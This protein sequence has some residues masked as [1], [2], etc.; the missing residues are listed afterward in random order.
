MTELDLE[1][2]SLQNRPNQSRL[3]Q[4]IIGRFVLAIIVSYLIVR[5]FIDF[6]FSFGIVFGALFLSVL[7]IIPLWSNINYLQI[8]KTNYDCVSVKKDGIS[9]EEDGKLIHFIPQTELSEIKLTFH[10]SI[11]DELNI[12]RDSFK[13]KSQIRSQDRIDRRFYLKISVK[14]KTS[15]KK[16][17][18]FC[19][20]SEYDESR[21]HKVMAKLIPY[22]SQNYNISFK[23]SRK[24]W[25]DGGGI[26]VKPDLYD[27]TPE[28]IMEQKEKGLVLTVKDGQEYLHF[29]YNKTLKLPNLI[30]MSIFI[31]I[32]I[33]VFSLFFVFFNLEVVP[34]LLSG[35]IK[36]IMGFLLLNPAFLVIL[37]I[38][39]KTIF[40]SI[41]KYRYRN[42]LFSFTP[43]GIQIQDT[44]KEGDIDLVPAEKLQL[45]RLSKPWYS[46][47]RGNSRSAQARNQVIYYDL[48]LR[49][50]T[51]EGQKRVFRTFLTTKNEDESRE[52]AGSIESYARDTWN[53]PEIINPYHKE[54]S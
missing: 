5:L 34:G 53:V 14:V 1:N 2:I 50:F 54:L 20:G 32:L 11:L 42:I 8:K 17:N 41:A 40:D 4:A 23:Y 25:V 37:S 9:L 19:I 22:I 29:R 48:T 45:I 44:R 47:T 43:K 39:V 7:V 10:A 46:T 21:T 27:F 15:S 51:I 35:D 18:F 26:Q 6:D 36:S 16:Q 33:G 3:T 12:F 52:M 31:S 49:I 13:T 28:K 38:F 30:F 24:K